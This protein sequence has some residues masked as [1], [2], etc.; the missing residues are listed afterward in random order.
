[1]KS[2]RKIL[3]L[4]LLLLALAPSITA[5]KTFTGIDRN[6]YPDDAALTALRQNFRYISYWLNNPP[7]ANSNSWVGKRKVVQSA[8]FG[9]LV[10]FNGRTY[11]QIKAAGDSWTPKAAEVPATL[12]TQ[13]N[14]AQFLKDHPDAAGK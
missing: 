2:R 6:D 7:G 10:I 5:Q 8:G 3:P 14:V 11:A 13:A 4:I 12:I 1:M 9:F